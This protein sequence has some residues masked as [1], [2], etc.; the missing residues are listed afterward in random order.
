M[1]NKRD[2]VTLGKKHWADYMLAG[3][4]A[5]GIGATAEGAIVHVDASTP[6]SGL[7]VLMDRKEVSAYA[8]NVKWNAATHAGRLG[9]VD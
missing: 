2:R 6:D 7:P 3:S 4:A 9:S 8:F 5:C 1:R